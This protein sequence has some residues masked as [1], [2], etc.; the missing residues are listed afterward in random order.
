MAA[1]QRRCPARDHRLPRPPGAVARGPGDR[2][3][4]VRTA[5]PAGP[6]PGLPGRD[7]QTDLGSPAE[8][9][10]AYQQVV[11][12]APDGQGLQIPPEELFLQYGTILVNHGRGRER[13]CSGW[14][15]AWPPSDRGRLLLPG[16]CAAQAG[17]HEAAEQAWQ[18]S[19]QL[20]PGGV[21][22]L[23]AL[24][25]GALQNRDT[26]AALKWLGR[27]EGVAE[28][29]YNTA[30][31]FQRVSTMRQDQ[32][33]AERWRK[34]AQELRQ[35]EQ[36]L[37]LVEQLMARSP[38]SFWANVAHAPPFRLAGQLAAGSKT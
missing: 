3:A 20:D 23:E 8:A 21:P 25:N 37:S 26:E 32:A 36:R 35:R 14:K 16:Q 2:P 34:K 29:R 28:S 38:H 9:I 12:L 4:F 19:L 5:G 27:L 31:L 1:G 11:E 24:A 18:K 15:R 17:N 10:K 6:R 33:A 7:P 30:Y 22:A 13:P